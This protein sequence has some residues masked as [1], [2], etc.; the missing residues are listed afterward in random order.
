MEFLW[1]FGPHFHWKFFLK[2]AVLHGP[3]RCRL[4][5]WFNDVLKLVRLSLFLVCFYLIEQSL[6]CIFHLLI[7]CNLFI[8]LRSKILLLLLF[9]I[10]IKMT[11]WSSNLSPS[12]PYLSFGI[13]C[14][15][16]WGWIAVW[17]SFAVLYRG[18]LGR[19]CKLSPLFF[20]TQL[21]APGSPRMERTLLF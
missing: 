4:F 13:I 7:I 14:D 9:V 8:Y 10:T 16:F 2:K 12:H 15:P 1:F 21:T 6:A 3:N 19:S 18:S 20:L 11:P 5:L 17:G